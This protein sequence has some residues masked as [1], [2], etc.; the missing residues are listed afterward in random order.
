MGFYHIFSTCTQLRHCISFQ[1]H[2][3]S[4]Q[5]CLVHKKGTRVGLEEKLFLL[6]GSLIEWLDGRKALHTHIPFL[7]GFSLSHTVWCTVPPEDPW[8]SLCIWLTSDLCGEVCRVARHKELQ[9]LIQV[10]CHKADVPGADAWPSNTK[11][12]YIVNIGQ[13]LLSKIELFT[14][15]SSF[16]NTL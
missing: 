1:S 4:Q 11:N 15:H 3:N 14:W 8:G 5:S 12:E 9:L 13:H 10:T 2:Q 16:C 6:F 7:F